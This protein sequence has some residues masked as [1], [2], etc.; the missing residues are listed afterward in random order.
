M[1]NS[2]SS[3]WHPRAARG[4]GNWFGCRASRGLA[5]SVGNW[6]R[7]GAHGR[8]AS[9]T[10]GGMGAI[11]VVLLAARE[12]GRRRGGE[13]E[14]GSWPRRQQ[15]GTTTLERRGH[16]WQGSRRGW[17]AKTGWSAAR[18]PWIP[19]LRDVGRRWFEIWEM[20]RGCDSHTRTWR[21]SL[22]RLLCCARE[23]VLDKRRTWSSW[24]AAARPRDEHARE[25]W[26]GLAPGPTG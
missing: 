22:A 23:A 8:S 9:C 5:S 4:W 6:P 18:A 19:G 16:G 25:T 11:R 17:G 12:Q 21:R 7:M 14:G 3:S 10:Q 15:R 20:N 2:L 26:C 1:N 24:W 13:G